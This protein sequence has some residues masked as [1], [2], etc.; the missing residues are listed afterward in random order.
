MPDLSRIKDVKKRLK[1]L[2]PQESVTDTSNW[3]N[4]N[5]SAPVLDTEDNQHTVRKLDFMR[6]E[7]RQSL[8]LK[9]MQKIHEDHNKKVSK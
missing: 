4:R 5:V 9:Q 2:P 8:S 1:T 3:E 7:E 6:P